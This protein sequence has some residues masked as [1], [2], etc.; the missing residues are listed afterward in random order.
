MLRS[1]RFDQLSIDQ[2]IWPTGCH[3]DH[4]MTILGILRLPFR[5]AR[6]PFSLA[7]LVVGVKQKICGRRF[8]LPVAGLDESKAQSILFALRRAA[9]TLQVS[10]LDNQGRGALK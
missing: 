8:H 2:R 1:D 6:L 7:L 5:L 10:F 9:T 3:T 4:S